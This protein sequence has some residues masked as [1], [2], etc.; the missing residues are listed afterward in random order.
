MA[1]TQEAA[2]AV[3]GPFID[4]VAGVLKHS[5]PF[6]AAALR[7]EVIG[8]RLTTD[9]WNRIAAL[10]A[11]LHA[12]PGFT[13]GQREHDVRNLALAAIPVAQ[14]MGAAG[15]GWRNPIGCREVALWMADEI[16][17]RIPS[18]REG[19]GDG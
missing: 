5:F 7:G 3:L 17:V 16:S 4:R 19:G 2:N 14:K 13:L 10:L 11:S 6:H 15:T 1:D 9:R 8:T 18:L 12:V